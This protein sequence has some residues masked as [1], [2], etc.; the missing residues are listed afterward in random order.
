M[1]ITNNN[2]SMEAIVEKYASMMNELEG[3]AKGD[4]TAAPRSGHDR[5]LAQSI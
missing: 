2:K 3:G 1:H 4:E 5:G